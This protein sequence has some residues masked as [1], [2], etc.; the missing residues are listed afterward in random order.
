MTKEVP[1]LMAEDDQ[2]DQLIAKKALRKAKLRNPLYFVNDGEELLDYLNRKPPFDDDEAYPFPGLVIL[3]MNMP[4][5]DGRQAL[6][7]IR[8]TPSLSNVPVV[9]LSTS[10]EEEEIWRGYNLGANSYICKPVN[11]EK[12]VTIM[13]SIGKYWFTIVEAP[14]DEN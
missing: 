5:K 9:I 11:F 10:S 14:D 6:M 1:I 12:M 4:R 8:S 7:E 3:D 13:Q 2:E